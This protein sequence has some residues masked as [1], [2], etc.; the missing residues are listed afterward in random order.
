MKKKNTIILGAGISGLITGYELIRKNIDL[1]ILEKSHTI[2]GR[3]ATRNIDDGIYDHGAQFFTAKSEYLKSLNNQMLKENITKAWDDASNEHTKYIG[4]NKIKDFPQYIAENLPILF[5][6]KIVK[7]DKNIDHWE[8]TSLSGNI[9]K[10]EKLIISFP[11]PQAMELI[12]SGN[13]KIDKQ[14]NEELSAIKYDRC[15]VLLGEFENSDIP[16]PGYIK[17]KNNHTVEWI[18]D[19]YQKGISPVKNSLTIHTTP[20][21]SLDNWEK[22]DEEVIQKII[23]SVKEYVSETYKNINIKKWKFSKSVNHYKE[24]FM[25]LENKPFLAL[26]GDGFA[27]PRVESALLSGLEISGY[28]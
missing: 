2:G 9:F 18:A 21:F 24:N 17:I 16:D 22:S 28:F 4:T 6:E 8:L 14:I 15:I 7:L 26:I 13:Y 10:T 1:L 25:I 11:V 5:N 19:N 20:K 12:N 23:E 27:G 3:I